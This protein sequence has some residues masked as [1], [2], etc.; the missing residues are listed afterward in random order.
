MDIKSL[1][2]F[3]AVAKYLN[4]TKA[5][6]ECKITQTA[7]S[8]HISKLESELNMAL[9]VRNNR[10]VSLT[11]GGRVFFEQA[12][13][14]LKDYKDAVELAHNASQGYDGF[15]KFGYSSFLE[16]FHIADHIR[17]FRQLYPHIKIEAVLS[18][19]I[20]LPDI[21][22]VSK[23]DIA[24]C[25]PYETMR[26]DDFSFIPL[27]RRPLRFIVRLD[28]PLAKMKAIDPRQLKD[29]DVYIISSSFM[30]NTAGIRT[31]EL[32][33]FGFD[34]N[35]LVEVNHIDDVLFSINTGFGI[36][37][38]P[39]YPLN[40]KVS[41]QITIDISGKAPHADLALVYNKSN[42]NPAL[43]IFLK[44]FNQKKNL[45]SSTIKKQ[46]TPK[47]NKPGSV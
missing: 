17:T 42:Q 43:K 36:G 26:D 33:K 19:N 39:F 31:H 30:R 4:F 29:R 9:F 25:L 27:V 16:A 34:P 11:P 10:N 7:M 13:K 12:Q 28:D 38:L 20:H 3:A 15:L 8:L 2:Y 5:A 14:I 44:F 40:D 18:R 24:I 22:R 45:P 37:L 47:K 46:Q 23:A 41:G 35:H 6:R 21:M 32:Q 1:N